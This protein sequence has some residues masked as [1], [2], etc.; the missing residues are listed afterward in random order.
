[1]AMARPV[2]TTDMPG[3]RTTVVEGVTGFLIPPHNVD[4]LTEKMSWFIEHPEQIPVMGNASYLF[5]RKNFDVQ[6]VN[7]QM[8]TIMEL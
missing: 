3:C 8:L 6:I 4:A 1:M 2:I 7:K 5:C